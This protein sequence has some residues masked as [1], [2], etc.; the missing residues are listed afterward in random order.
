MLWFINKLFKRFYDAYK[1]SNL[2]VYL[3]SFDYI[4]INYADATK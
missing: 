1:T 3:F 2:N 4:W